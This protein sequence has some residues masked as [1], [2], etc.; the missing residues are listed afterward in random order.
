M[1]PLHQQIL[2]RLTEELNPKVFEDCACDL[3]RD[4][5]PSLVP[6][7]GG[8]DAGMDGAIAD[9]EG[10]AFPLICTTREDF[11]RNLVES[12]DSYLAH[13][14]RRRRA[15][16]ATSREVTPTQRRLLE[17]AAH[18]RGFTLIQ[19]VDQQGIAQRLY[20]SPRWLQE[21][22]LSVAPSAL[23]AIPRSRRPLL[24]LEPIGR[25]EDLNWIQSTPGDLV[26]AGEP[27][28]GKTFLF[29]HLI[30][31]AWNGLF[32]V[33]Q[34]RGEIKKALLEQRPAVVVVDDAHVRPEVLEMLSHL[35]SEM[36]ADFSLVATTWTWERDLDGVAAALPGARRRELHLLPRHQ[37]LEIFQQA[38]VQG[39]DELLRELVDQAANKP[40]LAAT[41]AHLW[42]RGTWQEILEGKILHREVLAAF[43]S[44]GEKVEDLLAAFSLGGNRG[45]GLEP[46]RRFLNLDRPEIRSKTAALAAGGVLGEERE[47][48]LSVWPR[49]L[50]TSLLRTVFFTSPA[51]G[52]AYRELLAEA[53]SFAEAVREIAI[54]HQLGARVPEIHELVLQ[55]GIAE[56][57]AKL[58]W[59]LL[60][61]A[62]EEE[63]RWVLENYPGD[64][65]DVAYALLEHAPSEVIPLLLDR[66]AEEV[67]ARQRESRAISLLF[68]WVQEP[69]SNPWAEPVRRRELIALAAKR[70]LAKGRD[71]GTGV[72]GI[73]L[74]LKPN[75][76]GSSQ[77]PGLGQTVTLWSALLPLDAL[78]R[79]MHLWDDAK[80]A[81]PSLDRTAIQHLEST[82][83]DWIHPANAA[84][85]AAVPEESEREM[86]AFALRVLQDLIP[87]AQTS[88]G[89]RARL[90][91]LADQLD[92]TL[93]IELDPLFELLYPE[94]YGETEPARKAARQ[95]A[96][97]ALAREW[98]Q[99]GPE[100]M[101]GRLAGY[102]AEAERFGYSWPRG[103]QELCR[104]LAERADDP[105]PWLE[106]LLESGLASTFVS[107][108][109]ERLVRERRTG[110][111]QVAERCLE[112]KEYQFAA[113]DAIL[114]LKDAPSPLVRK[115]LDRAAIWPTAVEIL[116]LRREIPHENLR[117]ALRDPRWE[118]A[119]AA[120]FGEWYAGKQ[121]SVPADLRVDWREAILRAHTDGTR[122][123][124][125]HWLEVI[126]AQ[127]PDL[128]LDWL[129]SRLRDPD[130][131][132]YFLD[133]PFASAVRALRPEQRAQLLGELPA[134]P[135]LRSLLPRLVNRDAELYRQLLVRKE[136]W[137]YHLAPL[138]GKPDEAW[139][140][141]ALLALDSGHSPEQIAEAT[142][143]GPDG[144]FYGGPGVDYWEAWAQAFA[145]LESHA[146][147]ELREVGR[148][149]RRIIE[150]DLQRALLEQKQINLH[151]L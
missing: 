71:L 88:P 49:R 68:S 116:A 123:G 76:E 140:E 142:I 10:E 97:Q 102:E 111:E 135:I 91:R 7:R 43:G 139:S 41:I 61:G 57:S 55:A 30:R 150:H 128:A 14:R 59:R 101:A 90:A 44:A 6:V 70:F 77:D 17:D 18:E 107:P 54:V 45:M 3:L 92:E 120:A 22:G 117:A 58:A 60:A 72:H 42:K 98:G 74:A 50:R 21:L 146:W 13:G 121:S 80:D 16:F 19:I 149:G 63:S 145:P 127:A 83:W 84:R 134:A 100:G 113:V 24:D 73:C 65:L 122:T 81:I 136:L 79:I 75:Q 56:E 52:R 86:R 4:I 114:K 118:V 26:L 37:I 62:S 138:S 109:L 129:R 25:E 38:G 132:T 148:Q 95:E 33:D 31:E 51:Q 119:L 130:L 46:V 87:L 35:R 40:G 2:Q 66:A 144:H 64:L 112:M 141:L 47:G 15:V 1:D 39:S 27:G 103:T 82:L 28:S 105:L 5:Y 12:L 69:Y 124:L 147:A 89:L 94:S 36:G 53:P 104:L 85:G 99:L 8:Q 11:L 115:A 108:F 78:R 23:S 29:M 137:D 125:Q 34:N 110:W 32:L 20:W 133:G 131:T 96:L 93:S 9:G 151:G 126:L 48:A 67:R 143:W 106:T